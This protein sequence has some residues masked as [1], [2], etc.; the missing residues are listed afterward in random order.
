[1]MTPRSSCPGGDPTPLRGANLRLHYEINTLA[2]SPPVRASPSVRYAFW[3]GPISRRNRS[4]AC[5]RSLQTGRV[6]F[7]KQGRVTSRKRR[8]ATRPHR[9]PRTQV[10]GNRR[11][12][13]PRRNNPFRVADH[14]RPFERPRFLIGIAQFFKLGSEGLEPHEPQTIEVATGLNDH[15]QIV[16]WFTDASETHVWRIV[17]VS[18]CDLSAGF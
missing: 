5:R 7:G 4:Q 12:L 6:S 14:T 13:Q 15:G 9:G 1:M 8:R 10:E 3:P 2:Q 18:M 16:A 11:L 17:I